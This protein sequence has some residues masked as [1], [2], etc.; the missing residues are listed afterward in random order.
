MW[1]WLYQR[2]K[3]CQCKRESEW[4]WKWEWDFT[5]SERKRE[6]VLDKNR[7]FLSRNHSHSTFQFPPLF[8]FIYVWEKEKKYLPFRR[9][10]SAITYAQNYMGRLSMAKWWGNLHIF[11][12]TFDRCQI[13]SLRVWKGPKIKVENV[14]IQNHC[15]GILNLSRLRIL[16][17]FVVM[18]IFSNYTQSTSNTCFCHLF[19]HLFNLGL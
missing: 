5:F 6:M 10:W 18:D 15:L 11:N 9:I 1:V 2:T 4:K 8:L 14:K 13:C 16:N 3:E 19:L 17:L 7:W 12:A